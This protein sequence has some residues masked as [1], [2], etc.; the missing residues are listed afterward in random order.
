MKTILIT[1]ASSGIGKACAARFAKEGDIRLILTARRAD[2]LSELQTELTKE[3]VEV[4]T[5]TV[6]VQDRKA[7]ADM[8]ADLSSKKISVDVLINN[9]GLALGLTHISKGDPD[10]WDT[11]IDTNVKG[12]LYMTQ[13]A[14]KGMIENDSGHIVNVGSIA[15]K[16]AYANGA[17]YCASKAAVRFISDAL[18]QEVVDKKIR[19]TNIQP[20]MT[21]TNFSNVRFKGKTKKA[22]SVYAG[23]EA[24][25]GADL[26]DA[27]AY[28]V[29]VPQ[30]I[31]IAEMTIMPTHQASGGV[32]HRKES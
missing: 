10:D 3:G 4:V 7:V 17:V 16:W 12:L 6:D 8:F 5:Y 19:V 31:Q 22:E 27:I 14:L 18:R 25:T 9:A 1:G 2:V 32:V 23:I 28:A 20:G 13:C 30:N 15:G 11:M 21:E 29:L 24:L 26:A